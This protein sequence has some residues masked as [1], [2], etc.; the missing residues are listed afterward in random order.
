MGWSSTRT[1]CSCTWFTWLARWIPP[2]FQNTR[3]H[4]NIQFLFPTGDPDLY[5]R[6]LKRG[7]DAINC[8]RL[9]PL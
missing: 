7:A 1:S 8:D 4:A 5:V 9:R 2:G 3:E 6:L